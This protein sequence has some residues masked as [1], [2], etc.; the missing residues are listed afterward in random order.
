MSGLTGLWSR[1]VVL[2]AAN[3]DT[4]QIFPAYEATEFIQHCKALLEHPAAL[5]I[6]NTGD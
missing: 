4:D 2:S 3:I 5:F 1:T 6:S